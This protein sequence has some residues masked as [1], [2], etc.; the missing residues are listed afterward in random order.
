MTARSF[1]SHFARSS[2]GASANACD[3]GAGR[4]VLRANDGRALAS[5]SKSRVAA[6]RA[7]LARAARRRALMMPTRV[8]RAASTVLIVD[9]SRSGRERGG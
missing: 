4:D 8:P 9:A 3:G 7:P 1:V 6:L 2:E 5:A